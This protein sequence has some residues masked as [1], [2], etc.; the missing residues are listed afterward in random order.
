MPEIVAICPIC[1]KS[2]AKKHK[3]ERKCC[4]KEC[5]R[6]AQKNNRP[7]QISEQEIQERIS[8]VRK[9]KQQKGELTW[10]ERRNE[11][12]ME[13][14]RCYYNDLDSILREN[15]KES[16][17]VYKYVEFVGRRKYEFSNS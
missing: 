9:E 12:D 3:W 15:E 8:A 5:S 13:P 10:S 4:S 7:K 17:S 14:L 1:K 6:E 11:F 2:F 16:K